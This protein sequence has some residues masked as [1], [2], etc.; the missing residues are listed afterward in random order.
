MKNLYI[1]WNEERGCNE[2]EIQD[3]MELVKWDEE[4][5][6][7]VPDETN[8]SYDYNNQ[9]WANAVVTIDGVESYFV[10]IPRYAYKINYT[11]PGTPSRGG[12]IDVKFLKGMSNIASD[13]TVCKYADD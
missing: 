10:W 13:G 8:S 7:F 3:N 12:T 4:A 6:K 9:E 11:T 5:E 1:R 2:S